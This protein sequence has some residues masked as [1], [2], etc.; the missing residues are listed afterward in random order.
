MHLEH[1]FEAPHAG[2]QT[3]VRNLAVPLTQKG[4]EPGTFLR[5]RFAVFVL[6]L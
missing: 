3:K 2:D 1:I 4:D 6:R 5:T